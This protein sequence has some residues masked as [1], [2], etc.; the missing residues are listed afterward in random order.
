MGKNK[1]Q[2]HKKRQSK[3]VSVHR[4]PSMNGMQQVSRWTLFDTVPIAYTSI[5]ANPSI[6]STFQLAAG[7]N[8]WS[9]TVLQAGGIVGNQSA[10]YG[11]LTS[12]F[13]ELAKVW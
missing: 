13:A 7:P 10:L 9:W 2:R 6:P 8:G 12:Q 1:R 11:Q 5:D 4:A 3:S